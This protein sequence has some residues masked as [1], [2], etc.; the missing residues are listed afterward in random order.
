MMGRA[1][2]NNQFNF[3]VHH[4]ICIDRRDVDKYTEA[5]KQIEPS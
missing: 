4:Q 3:I 5:E 1:R 2:S